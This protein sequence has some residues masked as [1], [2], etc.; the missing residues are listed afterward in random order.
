MVRGSG[1]WRWVLGRFPWWRFF[2]GV[3]GGAAALLLTFL[4]WVLGLGTFLPEIALDFV[5]TRIPGSVESFS[6]GTMGEGAK[7]LGLLTAVAAI[8][9]SYGLGAAPF[10]RH[11]RRLP[12]EWA[13][14]MVY[15]G[16]TLVIVL[17]VVL[18]LLGAGLAGASTAGGVGLRRARRGAGRDAGA[19]VPERRR[20]I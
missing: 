3:A 17:L 13:L 15:T 19:A 8:L 2:A 16:G 6:I 5:V 4:L 14:I 9:A 1:A 12:N 11:E 10:R 18:S 20:G 7:V